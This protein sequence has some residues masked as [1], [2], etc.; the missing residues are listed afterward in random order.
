[1]LIYN[2]RIN[3][4]SM[5]YLNN[6]QLRKN[7]NYKTNNTSINTKLSFFQN[8]LI[9]AGC[10]SFIFYLNRDPILYDTGEFMCSSIVF[11][12]LITLSEYSSFIEASFFNV[13]RKF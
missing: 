9:S 5:L 8:Q 7:S 2:I 10:V 1:M 12:K 13:S 6:S 4:T 3:V 11:K